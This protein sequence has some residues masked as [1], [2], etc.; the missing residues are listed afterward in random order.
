MMKLFGMDFLEVYKGE[1]STHPSRWAH[2]PV[3]PEI[4]SRP[5][6]YLQKKPLIVNQSKNKSKKLLILTGDSITAGYLFSKLKK[7]G[8]SFVSVNL[9]EFIFSGE[10]GYS[11]EKGYWLKYKNQQIKL[12]GFH[13]V[14]Y[15]PPQFL[16]GLDAH[17]EILSMEEKILLSRWKNWLHDLEEFY[18]KEAWYPAPPSE[19]Y[20]SSQQ[21]LSDLIVASRLGIKTP[22]TIVTM[23]GKE[24]RKFISKYKGNVVFREYATRRVHKRGRLH[25]FKID[26]VNS[27]TKTFS[28]IA[29]SPTVLQQYIEK[30]CEYRVVVV[31]SR[32]F[33][34][35]ID[36]QSGEKSKKDWRA[37]EF[38][39]VSFKSG[40]LPNN[41]AIK[42]VEFARVRGFKFCS[43]DIIKDKKGDYYFLEMNRPGAWLF[44][45]AITGLNISD[46][47]IR[48]L[49]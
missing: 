4:F 2:P 38:E 20:E 46:Q 5:E 25:T 8:F 45:E 15:F 7:L 24:A 35:E 13:K 47:V 28:S 44:V 40:S 48:I 34:C 41:L 32:L 39:K 49:T 23:C 3:M 12:E 27:K 17:P 26:F 9:D 14:L 29:N 1:D 10:V 11:K 21:K 30:N 18:P 33:V 22:D 43:F 42:L 37:Y 36:S 6:Q 31:G 16:L 19:M